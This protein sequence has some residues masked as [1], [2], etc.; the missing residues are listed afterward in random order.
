MNLAFSF[1]IASRKEL[2]KTRAEIDGD[3]A[4]LNA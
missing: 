1:E 3:A 2:G 4:A